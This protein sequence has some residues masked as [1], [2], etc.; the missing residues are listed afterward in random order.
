MK[1]LVVSDKRTRVK[2]FHEQTVKGVAEILGA[3]GVDNHRALTPANIR[4]RISKLEVRP[5]SALVPWV[6]EG[7][8]LEGEIP[9]MWR[10]EFEISRSKSFRLSESLQDS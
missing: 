8:Y 5:L 3:M 2:N 10:H 6:P 7:S 4:R 1:G 9:E